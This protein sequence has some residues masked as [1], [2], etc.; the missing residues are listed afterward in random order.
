MTS[1]LWYYI[2]VPNSKRLSEGL[3]ERLSV[4][5]WLWASSNKTHKA[6][7]KLS[8]KFKKPLDKENTMCYNEKVAGEQRTMN[9]NAEWH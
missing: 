7:K 6:P 3:N 9:D 5:C 8:K 2:E 1:G 4:F